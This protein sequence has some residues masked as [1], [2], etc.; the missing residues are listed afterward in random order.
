M[1]QTLTAEWRLHPE[2]VSGQT[3]RA[4]ECLLKL[5]VS[6]HHLSQA[7]T[8]VNS[9]SPASLSSQSVSPTSSHSQIMSAF[10][11]NSASPY[12]H[13]LPGGSHSPIPPPALAALHRKQHEELAAYQARELLVL[14]QLAS[15]QQQQAATATGVKRGWSDDSATNQFDGFYADMKKRRM[16]PVYDAS[17]ID[18]LNSLVPPS[19]ASSYP[20]LPSVPSYFTPHFQ[21]QSYPPPPPAPQ[22]GNYPPFGPDIRSE[23]DL[24]MFNQF[25]VT[26]GRDAAYGPQMEQS[27]STS[28]SSASGDDLF[29]NDALASLGLAGM[30][31]IPEQTT[32]PSTVNFGSLYPSL[33]VNGLNM[34]RNT[35][36]GPGGREDV[37]KRTIAGLPRP[38]TTSFSN[39]SASLSAATPSSHSHSF[40]E[41]LAQGGG[42][43]DSSLGYDDRFG[44]DSLARSRGTALPSAHIAPKDYYKKAFRA[45]EPLGAAKPRES[46]ERS[47]I[48]EEDEEDA[49]AISPPLPL[50]ALLHDDEAN[51][52]F[53]LAAIAPQSS[54]G[55]HLPS[56]LR[57]R[58]STASPSSS[59][60]GS[61]ASIPLL[62]SIDA[63]LTGTLKR[64]T[65]ADGLARQVKRLELDT[66]AATAVSYDDESDDAET[67]IQAR[68]L[69][70][71]EKRRLHALWIRQ[72]I[73]SVNA[74][75][76]EQ[77]QRM[78]EDDDQVHSRGFD[79][80]RTPSVSVA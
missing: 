70:E 56:L 14:Q 35:S 1:T 74:A 32:P 16:E 62:P 50:A 28:G 37:S 46:A 36:P 17:M 42:L 60:S 39:R 66:D 73:V 41:T 76:R 57:S 24:A 44:F 77:Q 27:A 34:R 2:S 31:G 51:P 4:T 3:E 13:L 59:R 6:V 71:R 63:A 8:A 68:A 23:S 53:K 47:G 72:V 69:S 30:P 78:A 10:P 58:N 33:D 79:R 11:T 19:M 80:E 67:P 43:D 15:Q 52:E 55:G 38:P 26:L 20:G 22:Q 29:D 48:P 12:E 40:Y 5:R 25:M 65:T 18:R 64:P 54:S 75:F 9:L 45:V 7:L 49:E 61:P 21:Q